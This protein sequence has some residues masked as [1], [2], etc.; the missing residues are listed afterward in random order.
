MARSNQDDFDGYRKWLGISTKNRIPTHY[1]LLAVSLDE[2]DP[3]VI[4]AAAEQRRH[5]VESRRGEGHDD[6]VTEILY[7]IDEAE[8][9][10]LNT[11]LRRDYDRK[12]DLFEKRRKNRQVDPVTRRSGRYRGARTVGEDGGLI[13][14]FAAILGLVCLAFGGMA[15]FAFRV[16]QPKPVEI[17]PVAQAP[18]AVPPA[19]VAQGPVAVIKAP[20]QPAQLPENLVGKFPKALLQLTFDSN[21]TAGVTPELHGARYVSGRVGKALEFDGSSFAVVNFKLPIGNAPRSLAVWLK[22][23]RGPVANRLFHP[24][25]QGFAAG[26]T[27][28]IMEASGKWR[29]FDFNGGLDSGF[30]VD[31]EWHHHCVTTD[32]DTITYYFDGVKVAEV[33]RA[34][35][36]AVAPLMLGTYGND[37]EPEKRFVGVID[38]LMIFD[39]PI[40]QEQIQSLSEIHSI[41]DNTADSSGVNSVE[42]SPCICGGS[43]KM[44][45]FSLSINRYEFR[46]HLLQTI[47]RSSPSPLDSCHGIEQPPYRRDCACLN[48]E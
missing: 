37:I 16:Q 32:G 8:S 1:E 20:E 44:R 14:T 29:F 34:L 3:D 42:N 30:E 40:T 7:R 25:T 21:Q 45:L 11:A 33:R 6:L 22:D 27:F 23:T 9:T 26:T 15:W 5:Y 31:M 41:T 43:F 38:E 4:Q 12:M 17:P 2:D 47:R 24:V 28:G 10:L 19:Q 35:N 18:V 13:K 46:C 36:T 39:V 48:A